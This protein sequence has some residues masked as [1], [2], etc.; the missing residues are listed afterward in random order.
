[1]WP[2]QKYQVNNNLLISER[3]YTSLILNAGVLGCFW[4]QRLHFQNHRIHI[5]IYIYIFLGQ[6]ESIFRTLYLGSNG[7]IVQKINL[8]FSMSQPFCFQTFCL[9]LRRAHACALILM[10]ILQLN[11][12]SA[13]G[14]WQLCRSSLATKWLFVHVKL[15]CFVFSPGF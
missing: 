1:M 9:V 10:R 7:S 4:S 14:R 6:Q 13:A 15:F 2:S 11:P 5:Y 3:I 12:V 8:M